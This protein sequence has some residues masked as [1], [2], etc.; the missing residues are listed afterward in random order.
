M[1]QADSTTHRNLK[2]KTGGS[3]PGRPHTEAPE[4]RTL[5]KRQTR[6]VVP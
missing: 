5:S 4:A 1:N 2:S 6:Y 3:V